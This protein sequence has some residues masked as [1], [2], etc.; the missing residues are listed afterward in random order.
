MDIKKTIVILQ[1]N[2][3]PS[4]RWRAP[5]VE[6]SIS[7]EL[8]SVAFKLRWQE[9]KRHSTVAA[10][11][12][13]TATPASL[14][15]LQDAMGLRCSVSKWTQSPCITRTSERSSVPSSFRFF[16]LAKCRR[17]AKAR[18]MERF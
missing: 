17:Q 7:M 18:G 16:S 5:H 1:T 13:H 4:P 8:Q 6:T 12:S 2:K 10:G 11:Y 9:G 15:R 3:L 14:H